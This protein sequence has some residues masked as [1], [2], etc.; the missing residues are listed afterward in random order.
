MKTCSTRTVRTAIYT[1]NIDKASRHP[2][3]K[4]AIKLKTTS[5]ACTHTRKSQIH[6]IT[7]TISF[8][9]NLLRICHRCESRKQSEIV[10]HTDSNVDNTLGRLKDCPNALARIRLAYRTPMP[11]LA[12]ER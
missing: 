3:D 12:S 11:T 8:P 10:A 6:I 5:T 4:K 9:S 1:D 7:G 2:R